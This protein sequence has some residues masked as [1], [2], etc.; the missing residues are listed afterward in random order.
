MKQNKYSLTQNSFIRFMIIGFL[1]NALSFF[2]YVLT[3]LA[4]QNITVSSTFGY[5]L[6]VSTSFYFGKI[7]VFDSSR[8]FQIS[9]IIKFL[10]V[11][12]VGG[13]GMI[14]IIIYLNKD[15]E[16][17]YKLSWIGGAVFAIINNYF[18]SK[19]IVFKNKKSS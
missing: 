18:G 12:F 2:C 7:W 10:V 4:F 13:L 11:Y 9:E 8:N 16:I 17:G 6:G 1:S 3:F 14:L 5:L 15:L 19:Y